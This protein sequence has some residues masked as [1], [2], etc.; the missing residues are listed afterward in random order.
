MLYSNT[1][2]VIKFLWRGNKR[3]GLLLIRN[4][5]QLL[6]FQLS[7]QFYSFFNQSEEL[8]EEI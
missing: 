5:L 6:Q 2:T 1:L 7:V 3:F 4:Q 8:V